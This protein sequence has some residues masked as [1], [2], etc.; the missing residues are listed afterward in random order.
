MTP[1]PKGEPRISSHDHGNCG[2]CDQ[3]ERE[4]AELRREGWVLV[5]LELNDEMCWAVCERNRD[6]GKHCEKCPTVEDSPYGKAV[7]A[8][9]LK[10]ACDWGTM[11]SAAP[12][13][14]ERTP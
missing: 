2:L 13:V 11:L 7:R 1:T 8:C 12:K 10:W 4:L 5:P 14:T 9:R 6:E 3:I